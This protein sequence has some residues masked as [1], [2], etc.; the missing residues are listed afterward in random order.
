MDWKRVWEQ[1]ATGISSDFQLDRGRRQH[2]THIE[3][4]AE[5][6]LISFI[7]PTTSET[8]LDAGCGTGVNILRLHSRV[9]RMIGIDYSSG[10][11]ARCKR[12]LQD[13]GICT[14][15]IYNA[16]V[17]TLPL[18]DGSVDKVLCM[19]VLQYLDAQEVRQAFA[20]FIRVL[21]PGGVLILHVKNLSSLYWSTLLPAKKAKAL[22]T[23]KGQ[24][25]HVRHFKWYV[26]ELE[27]VGCDVLDYDS[28]N[29]L[30]VDMLPRKAVSM[31]RAVEVG[32][33]DDFF[34]RSRITRRYGA[35]LFIKARTRS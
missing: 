31:I 16:S 19:S 18:A 6:A 22:L 29:L 15:Q 10:S 27:S 11:L 25:E 21:K 20:E 7:E 13:H 28:F 23:G 5:Q 30:L 8:I 14:A 17:T 2:D 24:I 33:H 4:L 35:E 3:H 1:R 34:F 26:N 32:H 9:R 12:N